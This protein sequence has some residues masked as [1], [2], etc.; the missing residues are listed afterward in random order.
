MKDQGVL[1]PTTV[2]WTT[3]CQSTTRYV[4]AVGTAWSLLGSPR[5]VW[6]GS[7]V[8]RSKTFILL[9]VHSC[10]H[11]LSAF[12][13]WIETLRGARAAVPLS[14]TCLFTPSPPT[15]SNMA[16]PACVVETAGIVRAI[17]GR[18]TAVLVCRDPRLIPRM[19]AANDKYNRSCR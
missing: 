11:S 7:I 10:L 6:P 13:E 8:P 14:R 15:S 18:H 2:I 16:T 4:A 1:G 12:F 5:Q 9:A 3:T 17:H 19:G